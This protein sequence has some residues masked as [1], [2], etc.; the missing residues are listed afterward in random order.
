MAKSVVVRV[1]LQAIDSEP[2]DSKIR[3]LRAEKS[4]VDGR[5]FLESEIPGIPGVQFKDAVF[6]P[7]AGNEGRR[8][9]LQRILDKACV[10]AMDEP[11][12]LILI[13]EDIP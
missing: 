10:A 12:D 11:K 1:F 9:L 2:I 5:K 8:H 3:K 6:D 13:I 7:Y 4:P